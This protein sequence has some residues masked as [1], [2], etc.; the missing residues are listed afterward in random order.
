MAVALDRRLGGR[1]GGKSAAF[2]RVAIGPA[3][4]STQ[5]AAGDLSLLIDLATCPQAAIRHRSSGRMFARRRLLF[6]LLDQNRTPQIVLVLPLDS[7]RF[8]LVPRSLP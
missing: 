8:G 4:D 1:V 3:C 2:D 6:I 7:G 5:A